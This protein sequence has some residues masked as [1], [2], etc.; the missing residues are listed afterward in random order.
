MLRRFV[1]TFPQAQL[2]T[3]Q[4]VSNGNEIQGSEIALGATY[5]THYSL[6]Q[7][8][9]IVCLDAD[10]LAGHP[11]SLSHARSYAERRDPDGDWMNR[12]YVV[13]SQFFNHRC[14]SRS[15]APTEVER[16][17]RLSR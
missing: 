6:D 11:N 13:E 1:D 15:S 16:D 9:V 12:L 4:S 2:Y 10:L 7:A 8:K 5:R 17:W 3:R 14:G